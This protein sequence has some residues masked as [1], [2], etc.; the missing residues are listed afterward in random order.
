MII[1]YPDVRTG[2]IWK[3]VYDLEIVIPDFFSCLTICL[4][5]F[6]SRAGFRLNGRVLSTS[7]FAFCVVSELRTW[8]HD[9]FALLSGEHYLCVAFAGVCVRISLCEPLLH[10]L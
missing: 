5:N 7:C 2:S 6:T 4:F 8:S 1:I 9:L 10:T 3:T